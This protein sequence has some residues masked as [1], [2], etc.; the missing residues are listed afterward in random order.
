[1]VLISNVNLY[2]TGFCERRLDGVC[3]YCHFQ[4]LYGQF[5][6]RTGYPQLVS[7]LELD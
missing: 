7:N 4:K 3:D 6:Q 5:L 1:M 2:A